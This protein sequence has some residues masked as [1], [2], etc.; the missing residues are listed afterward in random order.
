MKT[1]TT[2]WRD[3]SRIATCKHTKTKSKYFDGHGRLS[4]PED[5]KCTSTH[6]K[7][8]VTREFMKGAIRGLQ[9]PGNS[10]MMPSL[11]C[12][13]VHLFSSDWERWPCPSKYFDLVSVCLR[14]PVLLWSFQFLLRVFSFL[15]LISCYSYLGTFLSTWCIWHKFLVN[16]CLTSFHDKFEII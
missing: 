5:S 8:G 13:H 2:N 3:H 11:S 10:L 4:Q 15:S 1:L 7:E 6:D 16:Y 14:V 12:V 9:P